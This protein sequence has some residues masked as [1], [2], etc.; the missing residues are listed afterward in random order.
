MGKKKAYTSSTQSGKVEIEHQID[1]K[2]FFSKISTVNFD[3]LWIF[4]DNKLLNYKNEY[5]LITKA[6]GNSNFDSLSKDSSHSFT[7]S[8]PSSLLKNLTAMIFSTYNL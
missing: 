1:W 5:S 2:G 4:L 8:L 6:I 3:N 7:G